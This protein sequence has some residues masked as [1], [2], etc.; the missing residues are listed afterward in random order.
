MRT[1]LKGMRRAPALPS[2]TTG[3]SAS[4]MPIVVP[5]TTVATLP[6]CAASTA[7]AICVLSPISA[8]K[9]A[10]AVSANAP[11]LLAATFVL[12]LRASSVFSAHRA[13][14]KN[15]AATNHRSHCAGSA[16]RHR[17]AD[18]GSERMVGQRGDED[19][20]D[21]RLAA[22]RAR[23]ASM[24]ATGS[25]RRAAECNHEN[26][27]EEASHGG[28]Q[29]F[30]RMAGGRG[31]PRRRGSRRL[32]PNVA[33]AALSVDATAKIV[34]FPDHEAPERLSQDSPS[35][36]THD[37]SSAACTRLFFRPAPRLRLRSPRRSR[38]RTSRPSSS[39]SALPLF[40]A[41]PHRRAAAGHGGRLAYLLAESGRFRPADHAHLEVPAGVTA[42]PLSGRRRRRSRRVRWLTTATRARCCCS[43]HRGPRRMRPLG[44]PLRCAPRPNGWSARKPAFPE[45]A[46][47]DLVLPVAARS[48]PYPHGARPSAT[49]E[50]LPRTVRAGWPRRR[51]RA[52]G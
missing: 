52:P 50:A 16:C 7:V 29:I 23:R 18:Q 32:P 28:D 47:L 38:R 45:E 8:T 34:P 11:K 49:R 2:S 25:C 36:L 30:G 1:S 9:N 3:T 13:T 24:R 5:A 21:D 22:G 10:P 43:R 35:I 37:F 40:P 6:N 12:C 46:D 15:D 4:S 44:E 19:A 51:A 39:P 33:R 31:H 17:I 48:D 42:G 27:D 41:G 14:P 20:E 26:R